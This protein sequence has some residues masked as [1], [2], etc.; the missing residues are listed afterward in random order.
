MLFPID[1]VFSKGIIARGEIGFFSD[2]Y[3][4][5]YFRKFYEGIF[6][7]S[8]LEVLGIVWVAVSVILI[9]HF[10][11]RYYC[12]MKEIDTYEKLED[13]QYRSRFYEI[14][15][16]KKGRF[17][18]EILRSSKIRI[19]MGI[20]IFKKRI[21]LPDEHYAD[22]ELYYILLHE[23]THFLNRD[24]IIKML[25]H[26]FCYIFWWNPIVYL[27]R[28]DLDQ[29]LEIKCDLHATEKMENCRKAD[30]LTTIVATL[31]RVN[32]KKN[33]KILSGTA[34]LVKS[35]NELDIIERFRMV[36]EKHIP[37][38]QNKVFT[39]MWIGIFIIILVLSYSFVIQP[40]Y[41]PLIR[42][43]ETE[44]GVYEVE[45]T[46]ENYYIIECANGIYVLCQL[47]GKMD[48]IEEEFALL[49]ETEGIEIR[50]DES[51]K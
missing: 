24:L 17:Q 26:M 34:T 25:I 2:F 46:P 21:I 14:S 32:G 42:E 29:T 40:S 38:G 48:E 27:L 3:D 18:V 1:F 4:T 16:N 9:I 28:K 15:N 49:L 13:G 12:V 31:R 11:F 37:W 19:P 10:W 23:Y 45:I 5:I 30:Y 43:I 22:M 36:S 50:K 44:P 47:N 20:G 7:I 35:S 51:I 39:T 33:P 8:I 41:D 6:S